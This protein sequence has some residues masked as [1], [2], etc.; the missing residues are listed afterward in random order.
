MDS[1]LG[2][3]LTDPWGTIRALL[4]TAWSWMQAWGPIAALAL[5]ITITALWALRRWWSNR[6]Q[7]ALHDN[8][9]IVT[10]LAPPT[11]D[12]EGAPAVWSNLVGLLR[13]MWTR[14]AQ[15]Q[16]HLAWEYVFGHDG[17]QI[18]LWVPGTVPPGMVERAVEA[19]W[20]GS[21][22][23][24]EPAAAPLPTRADGG[25]RRLVTGGV[26]RL[27]RSEA[28]PIRSDFD[29]DP[30]RALLGAPVGLG[31]YDGACVQVL[32]RPVTGRR[33]KQARRAAPARRALHPAGGPT[34]GRDHAG[35][36]ADGG[37]PRR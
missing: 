2:G 23:T 8:A 25:R 26:L 35:S 34:P 32:A 16:P 21:H 7:D 22:T 11:V 31:V 30:I 1:P 18:R 19:A 29:V 13:P 24:T 10:I 14:L 28:L 36:H 5:L 12:P 27:A 6:C 20:P 4:T 15:G 37:E 33:V 9:R 17:V 3:L